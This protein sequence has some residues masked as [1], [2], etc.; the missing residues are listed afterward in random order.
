MVR[1]ACSKGVVLL[2]ALMLFTT[3][4]VSGPKT[5]HANANK[6]KSPFFTTNNAASA[7]QSTQSHVES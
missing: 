6:Q 5:F 1:A 4:C 7:L 3:G 2:A